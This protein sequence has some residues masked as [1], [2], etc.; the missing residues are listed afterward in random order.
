M[1]PAAVHGKRDLIYAI[2]QGG[3]NAEKEDKIGSPGRL[4]QV[5][6]ISHF[7]Q[8]L[9]FRLVKPPACRKGSRL[10]SRNDIA[11]PVHM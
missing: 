8:H 2:L 5:K 7:Y 9:A 6:G 3:I 4:Q 11:G 10:V 1:D